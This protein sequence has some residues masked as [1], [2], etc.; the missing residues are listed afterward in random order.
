MKPVAEMALDTLRSFR[1]SM[2]P[3]SQFRTLA[4][5]QKADLKYEPFLDP[6]RID[7]I[8][9]ANTS[10]VAMC[11]RH[12]AETVASVPM[13][14]AVRAKGDD[15]AP[16][17]EPPPSIRGMA[18][19]P[20]AL[21]QKDHGATDWPGLRRFVDAN[22]HLVGRS[23]IQKLRIAGQT[24]LGQDPTP[25]NWT[26]EL[27]ALPWRYV[28]WELDTATG[29]VKK[30]IFTF[31]GKRE[32]INPAD[33]W[34]FSQG[35]N[36]DSPG[37]GRSTIEDIAI[38]SDLSFFIHA[39]QANFFRHGA[40]IGGVVTMDQTWDEI[41]PDE[42]EEDD[43]GNKIVK[44]QSQIDRFQ[45]WLIRTHS[46]I[47][48]FYLP[49]ILGEGM[50]YAESTLGAK[51]LEFLEGGQA[52]RDEICA[53]F[54]T[55]L[56]ELGV[57]PGAD[58]LGSTRSASERI[59]Y[60]QRLVLP[61][62]ADFG[63]SFAKNV[64]AEWPLPPGKEWVCYPDPSWGTVDREEQRADMLAELSSGNRITIASAR[65]WRAKRG[66]TE[67]I[68]DPNGLAD[69]LFVGT[70]TVAITDEN[71]GKAPGEP[72]PWDGPTRPPLPPKSQ[73]KKADH[74][75]TPAPAGGELLLDAPAP[76]LLV[77]GRAGSLYAASRSSQA[78][79]WRRLRQQGARSIQAAMVEALA[80]QEAALVAKLRR[81]YRPG[82]R[83]QKNLIRSIF[84]AQEAEAKRMVPFLRDPKFT[85]CARTSGW[86]VSSLKLKRRESDAPLLEI[87]DYD[88]TIDFIDEQ[89]FDFLLAFDETTVDDLEGIFAE[90]A[91]DGGDLEALVAEVHRYYGED[92]GEWRAW[93]DSRT[94]STGAMGWTS[95][96]VGAESGTDPLKTWVAT[97]DERSRASHLAAEAQYRDGIELSAA[98]QVGESELQYPCDTSGDLGEVMNCRCG[99][100]MVQ[101]KG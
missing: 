16:I 99:L 50:K 91:S 22:G 70:G 19:S 26:K 60:E 71:A 52:A 9:E 42:P 25:G 23:L 87:I 67:E 95:L 88:R 18:Y 75:T 44:P 29:T 59:T 84:P 1:A 74:V 76:R 21:M 17:E 31:A 98:F 72:E 39:S 61:R 14:I 94:A 24:P 43:D 38:A 51:D 81:Y 3:L 5:G 11:V 56:S 37:W 10:W 2:P 6:Q 35:T 65:E 7:S 86:V 45:A 57:H 34:F 13:R 47:G 80:P 49:L 8:V 55:P 96:E 90:V 79:A 36:I 82:P 58:G 27:R 48:N 78:G 54:S 53:G 20:F 73:T 93:R 85:L 32:E 62:A 28:S 41:D 83:P 97:H 68:R 33:V 64:L 30:W 63:K 89:S 92:A 15:R 100:V 101:R 46:G 66:Y 12:S 40:K 77:P 69:T 4:G